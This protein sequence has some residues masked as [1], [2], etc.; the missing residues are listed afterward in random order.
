MVEE[1][2]VVEEVKGLVFVVEV[3]EAVTGTSID[4]RGNWNQRG[5]LKLS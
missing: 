4:E 3:E 2:E 5:C 1:A